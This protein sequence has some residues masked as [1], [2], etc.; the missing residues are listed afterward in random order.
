MRNER[1][2]KKL[3]RKTRA[4]MKIVTLNMRGQR[5]ANPILPPNK[6]QG[7]NQMIKKC[8]IGILAIQEAHLSN[9]KRKEL[10]EQFQRLRIH[11]S[12]GDNP[13]AVGVAIVI[14]RDVIP[15]QEVKE[16]ILIPGRAMI[17]TVQ[18]HANLVIAILNVYAP[19]APQ[20]NESFW[21]NVL[22][23]A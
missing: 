7:I 6:W 4:A 11:N 2:K 18:W 12:Q 16:F 20:E 3:S 17:T 8:Q 22:T 23:E 1:S 15:D 13:R 14:N 9:K 19:N 5:S 21:K 10:E